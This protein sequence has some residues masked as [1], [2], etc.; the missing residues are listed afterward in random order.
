MIDR[1]IFQEKKAAFH[2]LGCKLNFSET[3]TMAR[4]M[5]D[6][7]FVRVDFNDFA[8][9][10]VINTCSVTEMA[11]K[12]CRAA[13]HKAIRQNP[14]AFIVVTGCF[15]QLKSGN[16]ATIPGV[17][18]VLGSNEKFDITAYLG[19]LDKHAMA[20]VHAGEILKDKAF[21][22]SYSLGDR[23][24]CFLKVQDGCDYYCSYCTIPLARGHSRNGS[25]ENTVAMAHQAA[26]E[27][28]RE[29]IL[30]GVN[31]GDFGKSTDETFFQLIQELDKI[32]D[33][34]RYR[35]SSIEPNLLTPE[36]IHFMAS[37]AKFMPHFHI[38]LQ[39][40]SDK[41]LKLMKRRY[42][43]ELFQ[44]RVDLIRQIIP[45]AF[46]GVDVIVGVRG[47]SAEDFETAHQFLSQL[48]VTQL[49]VFS[50]SERPNT[51]ALEIADPVSVDDKKHR[52][53]VLH[54]LSEK[55]LDAFYNR[56]INSVATILPESYNDHGM[57]YGYTDNYIKVEL[58]YEESVINTLQKVELFDINND[59]TAL[60][61]RII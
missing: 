34:W 12:K 23:T 16:V 13:I 31:I 32:E 54:L 61:G 11:E 22:P 60:K 43:T 6:E 44:Q 24:R 3:S 47:E 40:G 45:D 18:L 52:S 27:G 9:V 28:A 39:S 25:V 4:N 51:K 38:P 15:A 53:Q 14:K 41:V 21:H 57:M 29:I 46:I 36:I 37:S 49:H 8:D 58:P 42:N 17:D 20:E 10:Y 56:F 50:Y 33:I 1:S 19:H 2:T 48:D 30:T 35:V 26:S 7:G 5:V 55:K 59:R